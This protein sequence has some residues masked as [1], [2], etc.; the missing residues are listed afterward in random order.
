MAAAPLC[1]I[2][3]YVYVCAKQNDRALF[4]LRTRQKAPLNSLDRDTEILT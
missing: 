4:L 1:D 2:S 3:L